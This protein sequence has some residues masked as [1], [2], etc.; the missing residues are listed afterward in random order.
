MKIQLQI[1]I[2]IHNINTSI[3]VRIQLF[4]G[5]ESE[6]VIAKILHIRLLIGIQGQNHNTSSF[7]V[8]KCYLSERLRAGG[9]EDEDD[10]AGYPQRDGQL[11][12]QKSQAPE[13]GLSGIQ[14]SE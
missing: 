3:G 1:R 10:D 8:S 9:D 2:H 5:S 13:I 4:T 6:F 14:H 7:D 12:V 11:A